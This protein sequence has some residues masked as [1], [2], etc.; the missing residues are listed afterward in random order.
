LWLLTLSRIIASGSFSDTA[1]SFIVFLPSS[2][3]RRFLILSFYTKLIKISFY[4]SILETSEN[5]TTNISNIQKRPP[6]HPAPT[7][8]GV[9]FNL[10][11]FG[12]KRKGVFVKV[13][14]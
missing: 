11:P 4:F 10:S 5:Q 6:S 7:W 9:P 14:V 13:Q 2:S 8:A 1:N 12:E 3:L